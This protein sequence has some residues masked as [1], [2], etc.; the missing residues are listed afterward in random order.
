MVLLEFFTRSSH[1][2]RLLPQN[3]FSR[4]NVE[5]VAQVSVIIWLQRDPAM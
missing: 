4:K 1:R 5:I 3:L 2:F